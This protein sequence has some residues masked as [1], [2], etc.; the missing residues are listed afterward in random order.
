[1]QTYE[2]IYNYTTYLILYCTAFHIVMFAFKETVIGSLRNPAALVIYI[3]MGFSYVIVVIQYLS[4][5]STVFIEVKATRSRD[6][7]V[8]EISLFEWQF[9]TSYPKVQVMSSMDSFELY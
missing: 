3:E 1:M 7:N 6:Y 4:W 2:L 5:H 9:A 8:C